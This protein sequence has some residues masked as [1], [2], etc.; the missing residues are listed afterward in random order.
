MPSEYAEKAA[1]SV[2]DTPIAAGPFKQATKYRDF[3]L[4][5]CWTPAISRR[6]R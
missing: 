4:E 2:Q 1:I 6:D 3:Q 5:G